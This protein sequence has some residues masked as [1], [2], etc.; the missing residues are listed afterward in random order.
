MVYAK[1][2]TR[3]MPAQDTDLLRRLIIRHLRAQDSH[4]L[5]SVKAKQC[6]EYLEGQQWPKD[7]AEMIKKSGRAC[8]TI[9]KIAPLWRLVVGYQSSNRM[10]FNFMPN[11]S[12]A[13]SQEVADV[14]NM[15]MKSETNRMDL[16]Y[17]DSEVFADGITTGRGFWDCRLNFDENELGEMKIVA[18]DP[19]AVYVDPD[20]K[21]YDLSD[22]G[23]VHEESWVSID[24]VRECYGA[25]A[26]EKVQNIISPTYNSSI[27]ASFTNDHISPERLFGLVEDDKAMTWDRVFSSEFVDRQEKSLRLIDSQYKIRSLQKCFVDLETGDYEPIPD[28]WLKENNGIKVQQSLD[29]ANRLQNK[30]VV[31][32]RMVTRVRWTVSCGD[33]ILFD[34]WSPYKTFTKIG[35]FPYFR[36][37]KTSGMIHDLIDPQ[38]EINKKRSNIIDILSRNANSGWIYHEQALDNNQQALLEKYGSTPGVNVKYKSVPGLADA[39]PQRIEPGSYPAGLDKLE[40]KASND[41]FQI[42]GINESALGQLDRVQSGKAIE[43]RQRQAVLAIQLYQDNFSRSKKDQGKK[44]L[45]LLQNH[46]TESRVYRMMGDNGQPNQV[47]INQMLDDGVNGVQRLNDIS[48]GKYSVTID[49]TPMSATF[50]QAQWEETMQLFEKLGGVAQMLVQTNPGLLIDMSSLPRK[51]EWKN[52][53]AQASQA[54]SIQQQAETKQPAG[55]PPVA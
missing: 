10:D 44:C 25:E 37:G 53:L 26:A 3:T 6:T 34:D 32:D 33:L 18:A 29:Y 20:A 9:N 49:E 21:M 47:M 36:R 27:F 38:N 1:G 50:K 43:A 51:E 2:F 41:L 39:K 12:T 54:A 17:V 42:S 4:K 30:V 14:L 46:Y 23:F 40:E 55:A 11:A 45:E 19:F 48:V 8:V 16:K 15:V 13:A 52:A 35:F 31:A 24:E 5:W 7:I 22:A 28:E